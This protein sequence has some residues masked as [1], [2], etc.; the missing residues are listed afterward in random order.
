MNL[1]LDERGYLPLYLQFG[2]ELVIGVGDVDAQ[3]GETVLQADAIPML[4][5]SQL[6]AIHCPSVFVKCAF[7]G[8][9]QLPEAP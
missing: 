8:S 6:W 4:F 3:S 7:T 2:D 9:V 1:H 5:F